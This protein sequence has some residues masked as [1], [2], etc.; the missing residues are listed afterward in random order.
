MWIL[1]SMAQTIE[2]PQG[3]L[4]PILSTITT[5]LWQGHTSQSKFQS[6]LGKLQ[7]ASTAIPAG[8]S[9]LSLLYALINPESPS[10]IV[11][12][13]NLQCICLQLS[14][15]TAQALKDM[16]ALLWEMA[17]APTLVQQFVPGSPLYLDFCDASGLG[18]G[19]IWLPFDKYLCPFVWRLP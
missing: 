4:D 1:H 7:H 15:A 18:A 6:L 13:H 17:S 11:Q 14:S 8:Q 2:L 16:T 5:T 12:H 9:I 19:S 3:K 10:R